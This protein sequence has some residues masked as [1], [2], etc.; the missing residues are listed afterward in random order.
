[1]TLIWNAE[2]MAIDLAEPNTYQTA[3]GKGYWECAA[4]EPSSITLTNAGFFYSPFLVI[5]R[6]NDEAIYW[7]DCHA[8]RARNDGSGKR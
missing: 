2:P 7:K 6:R 4:N 8:L 5:A 1:M 3:C